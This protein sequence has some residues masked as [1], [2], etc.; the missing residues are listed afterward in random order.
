VVLELT[1]PHL[2]TICLWVVGHCILNAIA[3]VNYKITYCIVFMSTGVIHEEQ[4]PSE[5]MRMY[6]A[7]KKSSK[8][9]GITTPLVI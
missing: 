1:E 4:I 5:A 7:S 8:T 9:S 3:R 6:E 2:D